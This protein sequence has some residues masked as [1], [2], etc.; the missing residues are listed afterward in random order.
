MLHSMLELLRLK[1]STRLFDKSFSD[2]LSLLANIL[3]KSNSLLTTTYQEKNP[4]YPLSLDVKKIHVCLNHCILYHKEYKSLDRCP[5]C[6]VSQYNRND[7]CEGED[8]STNAKKKKSNAS[9]DEE[10]T[11]SNA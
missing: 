5:V 3:L 10:D 6:N 4:I 8:A 11:A 9:C 2:L 1:A 7:D